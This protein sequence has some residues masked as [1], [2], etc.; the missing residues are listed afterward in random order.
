MNDPNHYDVLVIGSGPAGQK[1]SIQAAKVG[2]H[3]AVIER[4]QGLGGACVHHGTIPSKTLREGALQ[5]D[6]FKRSATMVDVSLRAGFEIPSL[7][8]Q[9][10]QVVGAHVSYITDQLKRNGVECY[11]GRASFLSARSV[12]VLAPDRSV[13]ILTAD[14]II[15]ATGSKPRTPDT[16]PVDHENV[17]DSDSIV[18]MVYLPRSLTVLGGGVI[19]CEYASIFAS[20]GVSVTV[21]DRAPRPLQFMDREMTDGFLRSFAQKG[22]CYLASQPAATVRWDGVSKVVSRLADGRTVET[23]KML[24]AFGRTANLESLH[25][26]AAGLKVSDRG[27]LPVDEHYRTSVPHIYAVGDVIGPPALAASSMEQ[28]RRAV[29]HALGLD[30]GPA[31]ELTPIGVYTIPEMASVGITEEAAIARNGSAVVGRA[32]FT[33]VARGQISGIHD[34]MLKL[35]TDPNGK[36]LLG[37]HIIGD[38]ATEL[39]HVGQMGLLNECDADIFVENIFNFPTLAESYRVAALDVVKRRP[40]R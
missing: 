10:D 33:E 22:G 23:D 4:E 28:G 20:L 24:V 15:I 14:V 38:G 29:R 35:V 30:P 36:K 40:A 7:M 16:I 37:V 26:E 1:A 9:I 34:G 21:I 12:E 2:K 6:R 5:L 19:A 11:H 31:T 13:R 39:I 3:V 27:T 17:L 8:N 25:V 32:L 18:S